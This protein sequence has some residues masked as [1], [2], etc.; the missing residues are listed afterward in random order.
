[1]SIGDLVQQYRQQ[2]RWNLPNILSGLRLVGAFPLLGLLVLDQ[3]RPAGILLGVLGLTD[4]TDGWIARRRKLVSPFGEKL[5]P[6]AD[7]IVMICVGVGSLV[8]GLIPWQLLLLVLLREIGLG[9]TVAYL[10]VTKR[11]AFRVSWWGKVGAF[12]L[13]VS[14]TLFLTFQSAEGWAKSL[15]WTIG[16]FGVACSWWSVKSYLPHLRGGGGPKAAT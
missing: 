4:W 13:F 9:G 12:S 6:F 8:H 5:D 7:R 2:S 1:M 11:I 14:F 16:L 3:G 15:F 10:Y